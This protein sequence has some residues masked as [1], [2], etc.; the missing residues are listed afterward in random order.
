MQKTIDIK[1]LDMKFNDLYILRNISIGINKGEFVSIVGPSGCGKTT[2]LNIIGGFIKPTLGKLYHDGQQ[3]KKPSS[4]ISIIFQQHV[5]FPWMTVY[6]NIESGLKFKNVNK[7]KR[8]KVIDNFLENFNLKDYSRFYPYELSHGMR[9][10]VA[11]C[12]GLAIEP[13]IILMDEPFSSVDAI[14]RINLQKYLL[15][16]WDKYKNTIIFVTHDVEEAIFL[17][18]RIIIL[19]NKPAEIKK[20]FNI[21]F[22]RPREDNIKY[23]KE[24]VGLKKKISSLLL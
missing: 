4:E 6:E 13:A 23:T 15:N 22:N 5:L 1:N 10:K 8:I 12:R 20:E 9:Q 2:L 17:S 19:S 24:F 16:I 3:I 7:N 11:I 14:T 21:P 18:D